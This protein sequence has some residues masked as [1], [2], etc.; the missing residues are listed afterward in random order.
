MNDR[1]AAQQPGRPP[2]DE[3]GTALTMALVLTFVVAMIAGTM[4]LAVV[5]QSRNGVESQWHGRRLL[6]A[7]NGLAKGKVLVLEEY[8]GTMQDNT[9]GPVDD[10]SNQEIV[11]DGAQVF[12]YNATGATSSPWTYQIRSVGTVDADQGEQSRTLDMW[13]RVTDVPGGGLR[14]PGLGAIVANG[15]VKVNGSIDIDGHDHDKYGALVSPSVPDNDKPGIL[16]TQSVQQQ[17]GGHTLAGNPFKEEA[18]DK[19]EEESDTTDGVDND[20]DGLTD[21]DGFP[22]TAGAVFDFPDNDALK[23]AAQATDTYFVYQGIESDPDDDGDAAINPDLEAVFTRASDGMRYDEWIETQSKTDLGG[24]VYYL[25]VDPAVA[26][27]DP[28]NSIGQV[29]AP[30]NRAASGADPSVLIVS[31]VDPTIHD[32]MA[33]PLHVN[34]NNPLPES[35]GPSRSFQGVVMMDVIKHV[36]AGGIYVGSIYSFST[37]TDFRTIFGNGN[38][39]VRYSSEV[40]K[41]LPGANPSGGNVQIEILSWNEVR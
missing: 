37:A 8:D 16:T 29:D 24:K 12:V 21:E 33:G 19:W 35:G 31:H 32:V 10:A 23:A 38:A 34:D 9:T 20:G 41:S 22:E 1:P 26:P 5:A 7:E 2:A 30:D 25:E 11:Q 13:I 15:N 28:N 18:T 36:N 17:G 3:R 14:T 4:G 6:N 39:Q 27:Y 40:L